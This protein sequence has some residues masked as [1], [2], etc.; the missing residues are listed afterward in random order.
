MGLLFLF[1]SWAKM[2]VAIMACEPVP[3]FGGGPTNGRGPQRISSGER[4]RSGVVVE[5]WESE[6]EGFRG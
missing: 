3:Y 4:G 6:E 5:L 2:M 1:L